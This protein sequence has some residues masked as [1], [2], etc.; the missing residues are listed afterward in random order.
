MR[1][2][3]PRRG[4]LE[5]TDHISILRVLPQEA[6]TA[7][8][9]VISDSWMCIKRTSLFTVFAYSS[10][11]SQ[12][13]VFSVY[14]CGQPDSRGAD[15]LAIKTGSTILMRIAQ[16]KPH[17]S[18]KPNATTYYPTTQITY[19]LN[20]TCQKN[21]FNVIEVT[22]MPSY[23]PFYLVH[24]GGPGHMHPASDQQCSTPTFNLC[25]ST[26]PSTPLF[27]QSPASIWEFVMTHELLDWRLEV[28]E[29]PNKDNPY[30]GTPGAID[31]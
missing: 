17:K 14:F 25:C 20:Q 13:L 1:T 26:Y 12:F 10:Q 30:R 21:Y 24:Q 2:V 31:D 18:H 19:P 5:A 28:Y 6:S 16:A 29:T 7:K 15:K 27:L 11:H 23:L 9:F 4:Y 22:K 8:E 3:A